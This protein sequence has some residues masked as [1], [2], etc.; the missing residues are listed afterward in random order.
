MPITLQHIADAAKVSRTTVSLAMRNHPKIS[1]AV[2]QRVQA[3]ARKLEYRPNPLVAAHMA[4]LRA[5]RPANKG[6]CLAFV[7]NRPRREIQ[8]DARSPLWSYYCGARD[9]AHELGYDLPFFDVTAAGMTGRRLS[10]I[11]R[12]RGIRGLV[13]AL[14]HDWLG[15]SDLLIEWA[16]FA[17]ATIE[18]TVP[19]P[20]M[21][22]V[23]IDGFATIG[24][25]IQ[26]LL[27]AGCQRIGIA[28]HRRMDDHANHM[29][30]AGYQAF[31]ALAPE[32]DRLPHFITADW[33]REA[34]LKWYRRWRPDA[35][36]TINDDIVQWL[37]AEKVRI[38]Q[39]VSCVTL[40]WRKHREFLSGFYQNHEV[41][42]A[43]AVDLVVADLNCNELGLPARPKTVLIQA[44]WKDGQ[45]HRKRADTK[46]VHPFRI[47]IF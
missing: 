45:T 17:L 22:E 3:L 28:M 34:F 18:H 24:R 21:H 25:A 9:R 7:C 39:D 37:R 23:C 6:Q 14:H 2:R 40:Y 46:P 29:W 32:E 38:P 27:E 36:V 42:A 13:I 33:G 10:Q 44:D 31:Q 4:H 26:R 8:A 41:M 11:L 35:I 15:V 19:S 47:R 43:G 12:A 20:R 30:L 1:L 16:E 5:L